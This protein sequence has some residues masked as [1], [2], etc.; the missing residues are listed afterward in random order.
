MG[1]PVAQLVKNPPAMQ[2]TWV[3]S[4]GWEAAL[5]KERLPTPGFCP[6]EFRELYSPWG[7]K[8][9]DTTKRLSLHFISLSGNCGQKSPKFKSGDFLKLVAM[10]NLKAYQWIF[11]LFYTKICFAVLNSE[12]GFL[13]MHHFETSWKKSFKKCFTELSWSFKHKHTL[14]S[15]I[16]IIMFV[17]NHQSHQN[18]NIGKLSNSWWGIPVV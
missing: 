18:I 15:N 6:G 5:V 12:W 8:E 14:F 4:L 9:S 16:K 13:P 2:E 1:F 17:N 7:R 11:V 3:Q 10:W